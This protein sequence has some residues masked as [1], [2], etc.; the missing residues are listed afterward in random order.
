MLFDFSFARRSITCSLDLNDENFTITGLHLLAKN[1]PNLWALDIRWQCVCSR[2]VLTVFKQPD[3][4]ILIFS[5][6]C[7]HVSDTLSGI[8]WKSRLFHLDLFSISSSRDSNVAFTFVCSP[9]SRLSASISPPKVHALFS[10]DVSLFPI[11]VILS[12]IAFSFCLI[13]S[14]EHCSAI[15]PVSKRCVLQLTSFST[16]STYSNFFNCSAV[17]GPGFDSMSPQQSSD[18]KKAA[19]VEKQNGKRCGQG[20]SSKWR[21]PDR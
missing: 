15:C 13:S 20:S 16:W 14:T 11:F 8:P 5:S 2:F 1:C 10:T 6:L 12:S 19:D 21:S 3:K 4:A 18:R 17:I 7:D 9:F